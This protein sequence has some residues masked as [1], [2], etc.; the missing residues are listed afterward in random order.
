MANTD[1]RARAPAA[2]LKTG[3][4][5]LAQSMSLPPLFRWPGGKRWLTTRLHELIPASY[6]RYFEPLFGAGALFFSLVPSRAV[7]ADTNRE[8][9]NCYRVL[10]EQPGRVGHELKQMGTDESSYYRYRRER[11]A[12]EARQAARFMF[13]STHA[14][15][16][17]YR[18][19]RQGEFNVPYGRRQYPAMGAEERLPAYARFHVLVSNAHH[20]SVLRLYSGFRPLV[21]TRT[22]VMA[23]SSVYRGPIRE[24]LFTNV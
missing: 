24:Y 10:A 11:P 12:N 8:L 21:V 3:T 20:E 17:I 4:S 19:N 16:G 6:G 13:L 15:N 5:S 2:E 14:F 7:I 23:A 1:S 9:M 18:V 22:S